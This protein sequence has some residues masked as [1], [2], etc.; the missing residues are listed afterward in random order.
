MADTKK[1]CGWWKV[2]ITLF[3]IAIGLVLA[4]LVYSNVCDVPFVEVWQTC[5]GL[6]KKTTENPPATI[7]TTKVLVLQP[8]RA[9][10]AC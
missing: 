5:F 2:I 3:L 10:I 1:K 6:I 4:A 9:L 7:E 8:F